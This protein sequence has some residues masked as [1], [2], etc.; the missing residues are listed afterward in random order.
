VSA[1]VSDAYWR[2]AFSMHSVHVIIVG[3]GT[4]TIQISLVESPAEGTDVDW[5][6]MGS[7]L[8][9]SGIVPINQLVRW[10]RIKRNATIVPV[11]VNILSGARAN[12]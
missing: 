7:P 3:T 12:S 11:T 10:I 6:T 4:V 1:D 8:T 2:E 5:V 9:A